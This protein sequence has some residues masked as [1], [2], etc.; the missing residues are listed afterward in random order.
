MCGLFWAPFLGLCSCLRW[1]KEYAISC[2]LAPGFQ[3]TESGPEDSCVLKFP[4]ESHTYA[5]D[6][7]PSNWS[8][9]HGCGALEYYRCR[10]KLS[11]FSS[12]LH[13]YPLSTRVSAFR[14][15]G[16]LLAEQ[17]QVA[18][19]NPKVKNAIDGIWSL[20]QSLLCFGVTA[21]LMSSLIR[22]ECL[23]L[24]RS[25]CNCKN[26]VQLSSRWHM[27]L[28]SKLS[29]CS[30][31]LVIHIRLRRNY[32]LFPLRQK[33][34]FELMLLCQIFIP[35]LVNLLVSLRTNKSKRRQEQKQ[36]YV[37][38]WSHLEIPASFPLCTVGSI[39]YI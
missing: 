28:R 20:Q 29:L 19:P 25:F 9:L 4:A 7:S 36:N 11:E 34:H 31:V 37:T 35:S 22:W 1:R 13:S 5:E 38:E 32:L 3:D 15:Q 39:C 14:Y 12:P 10:T 18:S 33:Q 6:W 2:R 27:S 24:W 17:T 16:K 8:E 23:G 26:S 21:H 30:Q